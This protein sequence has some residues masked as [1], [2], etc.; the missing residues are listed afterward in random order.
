MNLTKK[1]I[2]KM[3]QIAQVNYGSY[4]LTNAEQ[5]GNLV[6]IWYF[7]LGKYD[8]QI[9]AD[10]F[11]RAIK[12]NK[13]SITPAH[14]IEQI[15]AI[16]SINEKTEQ[17]L[18]YELDKAIHTTRDLIAKFNYTAVPLGETRTQGELAR[19]EFDRVWDN[20]DPLIKDYL[21]NKQMLID[22]SLQTVDNLSYEKNRFFKAMPNLR[23]R[24]KIRDDI[25]NSALLENANNPINQI[26]SKNL[27]K[28]E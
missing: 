20:L 2:L 28:R 3:I 15:Y 18:W 25:K 11:K 24:K 22:M 6:D 16:K 27:Q 17:D 10:A 1:D 8:K 23:N 5:V 4:T 9:V 21:S 12:L 19:L 26:D 7:C 13:V 14:I